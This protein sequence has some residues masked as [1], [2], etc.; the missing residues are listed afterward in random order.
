MSLH[1]LSSHLTWHQPTRLMHKC[2]HL[3]HILCTRVVSC[4][5]LSLYQARPLVP[6]SPWPSARPQNCHLGSHDS[7]HILI[8]M[9]YLNTIVSQL[10]YAHGMHF[11][12]LLGIHFSLY[13]CPSSSLQQQPHFFIFSG[14]VP[15]DVWLSV[16]SATPSKT[17]C[18]SRSSLA[19]CC[20]LASA[21][22]ACC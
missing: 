16:W 4:P 13:F 12:L 19:S 18:C 14:V 10:S 2:F 6:S 15:A 22:A 17:P 7:T 8:N 21:S 3:T 1:S 20:A 11:P 5:S 9:F